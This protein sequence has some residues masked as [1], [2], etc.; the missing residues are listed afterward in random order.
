GYAQIAP[1]VPHAL[2]M[3]S[4]I[5]IRLG[6]WQEAAQ[7]NLAA[8]RAANHYARENFPTGTWDQ[9]MH[10]MDYLIYAYLQLGEIEK[11]RDILE[12][13]KTIKKAQ[14]ENTTSA[15]AFAAIPA[16]FAVERKNWR[17]AARLEFEPVDFPWDQFGWCEAITHFARGLGAARIGA[18]EDARKSLNRL[19]ALRNADQAAN[20][21]YTAGQIEI[22]R[23]A[24]AAWVARA[25]G[26]TRDAERFMRD[27]ADL[28]DSTEKDNVT[29]GPVLP[30]RELLGELLLELRRPEA[31]LKEFKASLVKAPNRR[32]G[33]DGSLQAQ[34]FVT[35]HLDAGSR[36]Q[37][38]ENRSK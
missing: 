21:H 6:Y 35:G 24:V 27:A 20:K 28:E 14:P 25:E 36:I 34:K 3:P 38:I 18:L 33:L 8:Y 17:E 12:E 7:S 29:P 5:F 4:H 13:L 15:Y 26:N 11:A 31:A 19:E 16:R 22:Q 30:A 1:A 32:N 23:L 2:H 10:H 9:Q 37:Q